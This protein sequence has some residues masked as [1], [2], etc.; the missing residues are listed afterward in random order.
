MH[1]FKAHTAASQLIEVGGLALGVAE[2][3]Q[4]GAEVIGHQEQDVNR[5]F[6]TGCK[7]G[8]AGEEGRNKKE[9]ETGHCEL[10]SLW[11][12]GT[13]DAVY[14][15]CC[16][17]QDSV[18]GVAQA[19]K[20]PGRGKLFRAIYLSGSPLSRKPCLPGHGDVKV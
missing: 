9:R 3:A 12:V 17:R 6:F 11:G 20:I 1:A 8:A 15:S 14:P 19:L 13:V 7:N 4:C 5:S 2:P 10:E 16:R 18:D